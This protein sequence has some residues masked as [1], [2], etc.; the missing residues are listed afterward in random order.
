M[1]PTPSLPADSASALVA[2]SDGVPFSAPAIHFTR[3]QK[4]SSAAVP[5]SVATDG[6]PMPSDPLEMS[7]EIRRL[8]IKCGLLEKEVMD[9]KA[10][11]NASEAHCT[12]MHR[13]AS[14]LMSQAESQKRKSRRP[15]KTKARL[16][17]CPGVHV[18]EAEFAARQEEKAHAAAEVMEKEAQKAAQEA[19]RQ[20]QMQE[21][22]RTRVFT[23]TWQESIQCVLN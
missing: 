8:R 3:S 5:V 1:L 23:G 13:A 17:A 12:I 20:A 2:R 7:S 19:Q 16:V 18:H 9:V 21:A 10:N 4:S 14:D 15:V 11:L 22:I 6:A